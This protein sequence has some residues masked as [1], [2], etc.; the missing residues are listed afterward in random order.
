[1]PRSGQ[2]DTDGRLVEGQVA[3]ADQ[4]RQDPGEVRL[5][6]RP[7]RARDGRHQEERRRHLHRTLLHGA[8]PEN[9]LGGGQFSGSPAG[10][11]GGGPVGGLGDFVPQKLTTFRS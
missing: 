5:G 7:V 10:S 2:P 6:D 4:R 9:E 3:Q 8:D 1:M 11:R